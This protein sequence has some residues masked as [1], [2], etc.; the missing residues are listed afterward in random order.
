M[1]LLFLL[2]DDR[3][4]A[5]PKIERYLVYLSVSLTAAHSLMKFAVLQDGGI[6]QIL[7]AAFKI[8][9][10][11]SVFQNLVVLVTEHVQMTLE[12]DPINRKCAGLIRAYHADGAEILARV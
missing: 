3:H 5:A 11:I 7:E 8:A 6:Q 4:S 9:V 10:Q 1:L 2:H 12:N